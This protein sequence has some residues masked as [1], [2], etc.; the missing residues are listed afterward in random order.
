MYR[1]IFGMK[2]WESVKCLQYLCGRSDLCHVVYKMQ[3][4]FLEDVHN[5][6]SNCSLVMF[7]IFSVQPCYDRTV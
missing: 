5:C 6:K 7:K 3:L 1:K 2:K 4:K